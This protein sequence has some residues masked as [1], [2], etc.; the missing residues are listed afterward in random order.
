MNISKGNMISL[1]HVKDNSLGIKGNGGVDDIAN[2]VRSNS[3]LVMTTFDRS[4]RCSM[5]EPVF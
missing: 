4:D 1:L 5:S 3:C 2:E